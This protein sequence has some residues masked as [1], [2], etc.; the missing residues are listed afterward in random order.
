MSPFK[1]RTREHIIADMS[2]N[3]VQRFFLRAGHTAAKV[4]FDYGYDLYVQTFG[5][6]GETEFGFCN[7]QIKATDRLTKVSNGQE[8]TIVI[9]RRDLEFWLGDTSLVY[10]I[11]YDAQTEEAYWMD[12]QENLSGRGFN[13]GNVT[14]RIP[15]TQRLDDAAIE[16]LYQRKKS[17]L[18]QERGKI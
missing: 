11:L 18:N 5:A 10:L 1:R 2:V 3:Y 14:I 8:C 15:I 9:Q 16:R 4:E 6:N 17:R 13:S 12:I 7:I